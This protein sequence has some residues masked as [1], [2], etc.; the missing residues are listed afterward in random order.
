MALPGNRV[1]EIPRC[2]SKAM[3]TRSLIGLLCSPLIPPQAVDGL[4]NI[5]PG[6]Y[7]RPALDFSHLKTEE[8]N[9]VNGPAPRFPN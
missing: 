6:S 9:K 4:A 7:R 1:V 8:E 5:A 3:N 2:R